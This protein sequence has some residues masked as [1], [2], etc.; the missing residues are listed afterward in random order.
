VQE[1]VLLALHVFGLAAPSLCNFGLFLVGALLGLLGNAALL[2]F[3]PFVFLTVYDHNLFVCYVH[4][5]MSVY[6]SVWIVFAR[7]C[8]GVDVKEY[9]VILRCLYTCRLRIYTF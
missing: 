7:V 8:V 3:L 1:G 5:C 9:N 2:L 6:V 4:V